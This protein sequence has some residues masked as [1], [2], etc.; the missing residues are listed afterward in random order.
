MKTL[1][2]ITLI[3]FLSLNIFSQNTDDIVI[4]KKIRIE[5]TVLDEERTIFVSTPSDYD[6]STTAYPVMYVL[7]GSENT[8]HFV[9]GLISNLSESTLCPNM[10]IVAIANT[11]RFRDMTPTPYDRDPNRPSGGA[12]KFLKFI[13]TELF[14]FIENEYRTLPYRLFKGH[15]ASGI[16]VTHAFLSH[17]HMFNAYIGISPS[18][19]WDSN[20]FSKTADE[21]LTGMNLKHKCF[22]FSIGSKETTHNV[23]GAQSF[24]EVLIKNNPK[25]LKWKFDHIQNEDHGSQGTI[26]MYNALR[27]IYSNWKFDFQMARSTGLTYIDDFCQ[28]QSEIYGYEISP[29]ESQMASIGDMMLRQKKY[30]EAIEIFQRNILKNP[31]SANAYDC[32]GEAYLAN[33]EFDLSI[34]NYEKAVE[35][36]ISNKDESLE[37]YNQNL[38]KAINTKIQNDDLSKDKVKVIYV[39]NAGF[40]IQIGDKKILVDALFNGYEGDYILPE[41]IQEKLINAQAPFDD[42]D[43]I[44]VTH[45]HGDH[46]DIEMVREH[47]KNNPKAIFASTKQLVDHMKDTTGRSFGFNP[48]KEGSDKKEIGDFIVETFFLPHG[49]DSRIVNIGFL[50]LVKGITIF[51]SGDADFDQFTFEEFRSLQLPE[52]NIDLSF[53]QHFYLT[54][55]STSRQFVTKGIGGKYVFPIHYH[56]TTPAFDSIIV[57]ENYLNAIIFSEELQT[58]HMPKDEPKV[59]KLEGKYLGQTPPGDI[60]VV[61][62]PGIISVDS[63]I[64]HGS[65][66]FSPDGIEV[67]WQSNYR[68]VGEE[69]RINCMTMR[70]EDGLWTTPEISPY[71]S[72]PVFSPDGKQLYYNSEENKGTICFIEK[73]GE[74]W[75]KPKNLGFIT[76]FPEIKFVYN[77]SFTENG[78]LYFLGYDEGLGTMNDYGIYRSELVDG[79]YKKP[80]LL[81]PSINMAE[82]VLN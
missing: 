4:A 51:Q 80:E 30:S 52:K 61:F 6:Q 56:F 47:M 25:D 59:T 60:P 81:P 73:E 75:S 17:N 8:I 79:V 42:V 48:S 41:H 24:S 20:L 22:Y 53:I 12:D 63:T 82:G 36:G 18:M 10:I 77:L 40:L 55:D 70:R 1:N 68:M 54:D 46:L 50:V 32:L 44:L 58:W 37:I 19:W 71:G 64:E 76:H 28:K 14:P 69:T 7:D 33:A 13:E 35:L 34:K 38:E 67:F 45:T 31:Q 78:T 11:D 3:I 62:A 27:F 49:P 21:K 66:T 72:G 15:S 23:E 43:L 16:C 74:I 39:G 57:K 5:S 65:P 29:S 9:S 2:L 26:A